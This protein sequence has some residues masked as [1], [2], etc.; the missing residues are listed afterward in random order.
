M[1]WVCVGRKEWRTNSTKLR[2][3]A[4][5]EYCDKPHC[6]DGMAQQ[7]QQQQQPITEVLGVLKL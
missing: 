4:D 3:E 1:V 7:Q 6:P 2:A 5:F